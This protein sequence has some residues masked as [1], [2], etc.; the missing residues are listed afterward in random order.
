M[1]R[2]GA[3]CLHTGLCSPRVLT[4]L[5]GHEL[6]NMGM[7]L[8]TGHL[9]QW[10]S[11]SI[12]CNRQSDTGNA[13]LANCCSPCQRAV[14]NVSLSS[15]VFVTLFSSSFFVS[16]LL[17]PLALLLFPFLFLIF[18]RALC[19]QFLYFVWKRVETGGAT[20]CCWKRWGRVHTVSYF[21]CISI[22]TFTLAVKNSC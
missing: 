7:W 19:P 20:G 4:L 14:R 9:K 17:C 18:K 22:G 1:V 10:K 15:R 6:G 11:K 13:M 2:R 16:Y 12:G 5:E 21:V 3:R 8:L